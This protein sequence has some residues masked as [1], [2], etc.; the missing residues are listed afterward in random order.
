MKYTDEQIEEIIR[1][2]KRPSARELR[3]MDDWDRHFL[4]LNIEHAKS[5]AAKALPV[6]WQELLRLRRAMNKRARR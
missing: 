4:P 3:A 2:M 1:D 6:L 5:E